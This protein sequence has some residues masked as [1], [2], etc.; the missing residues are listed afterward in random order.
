MARAR[1]I[2]ARLGR[3]CLAVTTVAASTLLVA[4]GPAQAITTPVA[5]QPCGQDDLGRRAPKVASA[6]ADRVVTHFSAI[7]VSSGS[8]TETEYTLE[9]TDQVITEIAKNV[10]VSTK[11]TLASIFEIGATVGFNVKD[12][13]THTEL[14]RTRILWRF[15][16]P[17][18]YG[19]YKGTNRARGALNSL[20][21]HRVTQT[22]GTQQLQW[23]NHTGGQFT[24]FGFVEQGSVRCE[25]TYPVGTL[26]YNAQRW[27]CGFAAVP[28]AP[29]PGPKP[30]AK[31][32]PREAGSLAIPPEYTCE[33][34][35]YRLEARNGLTLTPMIS[36]YILR[37]DTPTNPRYV[38]WSQWRLCHTAAEYPE[39][40]FV[41]VGLGLCMG[42]AGGSLAEEAQIVALPCDYTPNQRFV[43]HRDVAG[44]TKVGI[45]SVN[46]GSMLATLGG[47]L[48]VQ[49]II[50]QYSTGRDDYTGTFS[51][52]PV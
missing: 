37:T 46:S 19:L 28:A 11:F 25:E 13:N 29:R 48:A 18:Y 36:T 42:V 22:N 43:L 1:S 45:Q 52:I 50:A 49:A 44:S 40:V 47:S 7:N 32:Q 20:Q 26:R 16:E 14:E 3:V 6:T 21:C 27:L 8:N 41:N 31:A 35:I 23:V 24:T 17:G 9:V 4:A 33:S 30:A 15:T 12:V 51:L 39:T 34:Q 5:G 2:P 38:P 10:S